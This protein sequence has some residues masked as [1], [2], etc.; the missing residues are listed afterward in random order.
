MFA[1]TLY[2]GINTTRTTVGFQPQTG[3]LSQVQQALALELMNLL[4]RI[5]QAPVMQAAQNPLSLLFPAPQGYHPMM[6]NNL[7]GA[8]AALGN[9]LATAADGQGSV[10]QMLLALARMTGAPTA[11][12][13]GNMAGTIGSNVPNPV[14]PGP[15]TPTT[16]SCPDKFAVA[17]T[18]RGNRASPSN[19][20]N[21]P[22]VTLAIY[23]I[24][25]QKGNKHLTPAKLAQKLQEQYGIHAE[26][27]TIKDDK[28][29]AHKALKFDNGDIF[30]D[31]NGNG[32]LE[33]KDYNFK[34]AI[35]DIKAR[36]GVEATDVEKLKQIVEG[37]GAAQAPQQNPTAQF[38]AQAQA[39]TAGGVGG[40][41]PLNDIA[42]LFAAA[43]RY[44]QA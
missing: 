22:H 17:S 8:Q 18:C 25:S 29:K 43:F 11:Q 20:N 35:E 19:M 9:Q 10:A 14:I 36:Y 30:A 4:D 16:P 37:G 28:G 39:L 31:G 27:T 13:A 26:V 32:L 15:S 21:S 2:A 23:D 38:A 1:P 24:L 33:V 41:F 7:G 12:I 5:G 40:A 34:G 44:A 3:A 6:L 42:A